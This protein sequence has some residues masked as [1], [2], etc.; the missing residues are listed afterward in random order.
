MEKEV[1]LKPKQRQQR[2]LVVIMARNKG[3]G[4]WKILQLSPEQR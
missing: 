3:D 2:Q 1:H 4:K